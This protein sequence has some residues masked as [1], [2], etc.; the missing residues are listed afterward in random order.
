MNDCIFCKIINKETPS[1]IVYEDD[2]VIAFNDINP[3]ARVHVLIVPKEHIENINDLNDS[4][5]S[6]IISIHMAAKKIAEKLG[7]KDS[8]YR[9]ISNC[10]KGAGQTVFHLHYHLLSGK[11]VGINIL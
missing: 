10:G 4:N 5:S 7:V 2:K 9:L 6:Y 1:T 11:E 3:S 8:G